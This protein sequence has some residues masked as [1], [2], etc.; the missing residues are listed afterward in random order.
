MANKKLT[1]NP[2]TGL[3]HTAFPVM[4]LAGVAGILCLIGQPLLRGIWGIEVN[5][6]EVG[7]S[8]LGIAGVSALSM[9][10]RA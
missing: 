4:W 5:L 8:L 6:N 9:A 1:V 10:R 7:W 3:K 2:Q